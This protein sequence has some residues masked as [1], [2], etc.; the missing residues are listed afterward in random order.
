MIGGRVLDTSALLAFA[1][2]S[3]AYVHALVTAAVQESIVLLAPTTALADAWS[4]LGER[5]RG[6]LEVL[7]GLHVTVLDPLDGDRAREIG[8][9]QTTDAGVSAAAHA[10]TCARAR[11]WAIVTTQPDRYTGY[12]VETEPVA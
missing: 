1:R 8:Q 5:Q 6:M 9:L 3:S 10:I 11:A 2:Q 12:D 4:V 7:L